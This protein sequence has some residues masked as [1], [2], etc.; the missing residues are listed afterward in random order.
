MATW[1]EVGWIL[2]NSFK[3]LSWFKNKTPSI[4][5]R[6]KNFLQPHRYYCWKSHMKLS[7]ANCWVITGTHR[8]AKLY[9]MTVM[10]KGDLETWKRIFLIRY[11]WRWS[12]WSPSRWWHSRVSI[13]NSPRGVWGETLCRHLMES[14]SEDWYSMR[15]SF[16]SKRLSSIT[17]AT[18]APITWDKSDRLWG[19]VHRI[20]QQEEILQK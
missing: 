18:M 6:K 10:R 13:H 8:L 16:F 4:R 17:S 14:L 20:T 9:V 1:T 3:H 19:Q 12:W 2:L 15:C 11:E 5:H 7:Y